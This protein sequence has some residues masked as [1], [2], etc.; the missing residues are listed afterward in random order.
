MRLTSLLSRGVLVALAISLCCGAANAKRYMLYT[1]ATLAQAGVVT[2]SVQQAHYFEDG[3]VV[4]ITAQPYDGFDFVCW[5]GDVENPTSRTTKVVMDGPR[6]VVASF[7]VSQSND[8]IQMGIKSL[9]EGGTGNTLIT[10]NI[11]SDSITSTN[12]SSNVSSYLAA[13]DRPGTLAKPSVVD[14]SA[15]DYRRPTDSN[16]NPIIPEPATITILAAGA[17]GV[18][19]RKMRK[20]NSN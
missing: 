6:Y 13:A 20:K 2:P 12:Y 5:I 7:Q 3:E 16:P 19:V 4:T 11:T 8:S 10:N 14:V 9:E 15:P 18:A 17:V 1:D